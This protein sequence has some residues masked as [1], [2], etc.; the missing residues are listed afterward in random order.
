MEYIDS[1]DLEQ[2]IYNYQSSNRAFSEFEVWNI[3]IQM[4]RGLSSLHD[5]DVMHR[6]IKTAN[7]FLNKN[8]SV[9][10]GDMNVSKVIQN[11]LLSTQTGT[12]Y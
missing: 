1:G 5:I 6:D 7:I 12:P 8:K 11:D 4:L 2:K 10:L 9:K 3:F